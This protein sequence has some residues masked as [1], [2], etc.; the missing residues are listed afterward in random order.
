MKGAQGRG[1]WAAPLE[2]RGERG[3]VER[4]LPGGLC[5]AALLLSAGALG[6]HLARS[7]PRR[8][9]D[10]AEGRQEVQA[11]SSQVYIEDSL[12][13]RI[14]VDSPHCKTF[15]DNIQ[16]AF[17]TKMP[18]KSVLLQGEAGRSGGELSAGERGWAAGPGFPAGGAGAVRLPP[19]RQAPPGAWV[20]EGQLG[21]RIHELLVCREQP[22]P[23]PHGG[24][25]QPDGAADRGGEAQPGSGGPAHAQVG[26]LRAPPCQA[27]PRGGPARRLPA[28]LPSPLWPRYEELA[29]SVEEY[30]LDVLRDQLTRRQPIDSVSRNLL[31]L[32]T[33]TCGYK[34]VRLMAVQKLEMWLQNPKVRGAVRAG[35]RRRAR[36]WG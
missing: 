21:A 31:R 20:P 27:P 29:E 1:R 17:N 12:G 24:G 14:W 34:E 6:K 25:G 18:P 36:P 28:R 13:E 23:L 30:V 33:S 22:P 16:T 9:W 7:F 11:S 15:V 19:R 3:A 4:V 26:A 5:L 10:V 2:P 32:L 35:P 8:R